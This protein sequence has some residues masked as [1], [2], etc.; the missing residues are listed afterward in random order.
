MKL[1]VKSD[2]FLDAVL[3]K[4]YLRIVKKNTVDVYLFNNI[5]PLIILCNFVY[6]L[7]PSNSL[8]GLCK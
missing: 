6:N 5:H 7:N 4:L 3:R 1:Y 8:D 2:K